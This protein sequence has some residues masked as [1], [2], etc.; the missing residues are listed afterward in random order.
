MNDEIELKE[1]DNE[2]KKKLYLTL[3]IIEAKGIPKRKITNLS[4]L[5][6]S[7][8]RYFTINLVKNPWE[9]SKVSKTEIDRYFY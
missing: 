7:T 3:H 8:E 1:I 4:H 9:K 2:T 6:L 5:N